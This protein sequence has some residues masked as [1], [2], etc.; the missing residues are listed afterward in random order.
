MGAAAAIRLSALLATTAL[1][2]QPDPA[3]LVPLY[4]QALAEREKRFGANHPAVARAASDLGLFLRNQGDRAAAQLLLRRALAIDEKTLGPGTVVTGED[5]ENLASVLPALQALPLVR[6]ASE[7]PDAAIAARNLAKLAEAADSNSAT[8]ALYQR[9]L[10][11]EEAVAGPNHPRVAVRLNDVALFVERA[12]AAALLRRA[13]AIQESSVG[14][15][16]PETA[17]TLSNLSSVLLS[18]GRAAEAEPLARRALSIFEATLG[19]EHQ[20][21]ATAASNL[22]DILRARKNYVGARPLYERAL[23][24][25]EKAFAPNALAPDIE[26]LAELLDQMGLRDEARR[27]RLKGAR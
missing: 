12:Q 4:R 1:A 22:A 21:V 19:P 18:T 25:H 10:M 16:H 5:L 15:R 27:V 13:L 23:A 14:P 20:R 11:K 7:H 24:I 6:R 26:N 9:A 3:A 2:W 17:V 8:L